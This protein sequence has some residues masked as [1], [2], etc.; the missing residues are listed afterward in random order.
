MRM[1]VLI[2]SPKIIITGLILLLLSVCGCGRSGRPYVYYLNYKPEADAAWQELATE[3]TEL[4][5]VPV[6]VVTAASNTYSDTLGAQLNKSACPTFF[7]CS[8]IQ[9]V[10]NMG[11]YPLDLNGTKLADRLMT[12]D[13]CLEGEN[14]ELYGIGFCY[15]AYGLITNKALLKEAGY[16]VC[17]INNFNQLKAAAEDIHNRRDELG[18][19]AFTSSGLDASSSWRF[20][21]HLANMPLYCEFEKNGIV[22]QPAEITGEYID[23]YKNTWDLYINNGTAAGNELSSA[24]GNRAEDEFGSGKA[25]FY[26]NGTWEYSILTDPEKYGMAPDDLAMIPIYCGAQGEEN[27]GLC[28]GTENYWVIN[29]KADQESIDATLDFLDWVVTSEAGRKMLADEFGVTPFKD[30]LPTDNVFF[31]DEQRYEE[32]GRHPVTWEFSKTPNADVWRSG[33]TSAL[34]GYSAGNGTW[35]D[36][37]NAFINGWKYQYRLEHGIM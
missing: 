37:E 30:A 21:G 24:T 22:T 25:V 7:N 4:T 33:V 36:V 8:N 18:F 15:E 1:P 31:Q 17:D 32:A 19:D 26:Q 35:E 28:C 9:E 10:E 5:G 13:F 29:S 16:D 11:D 6:K 2:K 14:G 27:F 12:R 34:T 3:Y 20:S 23:L